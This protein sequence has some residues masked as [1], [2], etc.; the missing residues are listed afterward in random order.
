MTDTCE[1]CTYFEQALKR[2]DT[3]YEPNHGKCRRFP[4]IGRM[5]VKTNNTFFP[6]T[7]KP[8]WCGEYKRKCDD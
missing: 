1:T 7:W 6:D 3:P 2:S 8:E 5:E 4:P